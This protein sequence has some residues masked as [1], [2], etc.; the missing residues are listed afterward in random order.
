MSQLSKVANVLQKNNRGAGITVA[1]V[2]RLTGVPK[3]SVSK[4]VYDLR[5]LEGHTIYSNYRKVNGQRKLYY[6]F[7]A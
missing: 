4:R 2:A 3:T 6:R 5:N 1:Q 7:A